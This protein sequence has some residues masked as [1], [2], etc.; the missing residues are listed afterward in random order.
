MEKTVVDFNEAALRFFNSNNEIL[1][2]VGGLL[3]IVTLVLG[4]T[5][6]KGKKVPGE[7]KMSK[8][9]EYLLN[10]RQR[11]LKQKSWLADG[12]AALLLDGYVKGV[13][14]EQEYELWHLRFGKRLALY[15]LLPKK[16]TT[17]Q[18]KE[19]VKKRRSSD[20]YKKIVPVPVVKETKK[21]TI[22]DQILA[23]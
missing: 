18:T 11:R 14:D 5:L 22:I 1:L 2:V 15:D 13:L 16:L 3:V 21:K 10:K 20:F 4:F 19:A 9:D 12:V 23:A 7:G 6:H 8:K 17:Q